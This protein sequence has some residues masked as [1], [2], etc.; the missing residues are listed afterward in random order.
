M[1]EPARPD[2]Q[3]EVR[4][5]PDPIRPKLPAEN[6][7]LWFACGAAVGA[8]AGLFV[9][10]KLFLLS[11]TAVVLTVAIS[12][13]ACGVCSVYFGEGFWDRLCSALRFIRW[14]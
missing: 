9:A 14:F 8:L 13:L 10:F 3:S 5:Y 12:S 6:V 7:L 4:I 11:S 2:S 1:S